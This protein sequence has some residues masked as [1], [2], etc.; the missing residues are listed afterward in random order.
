MATLVLYFRFL[1]F[2]WFADFTNSF[3]QYEAVYGNKANLLF[4]IDSLNGLYELAV[5]QRQTDEESLNHFFN[6]LA[7]KAGA[8]VREME[9]NT[10]SAK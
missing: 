1:L 3:N 9:M 2:F 7:H 4:L 6:S 10:D 8:N 5:N